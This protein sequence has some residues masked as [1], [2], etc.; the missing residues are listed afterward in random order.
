MPRARRVSGDID[1]N[2]VP[3]SVVA[4]MTRNLAMLL[5]AGVPIASALESLAIQS[6]NRGFRAVLVAIRNSLLEGLSLSQAIALYPSIFREPYAD[7]IRAGE[8]G[9]ALDSVLEK[10]AQHLEREQQIRRELLHAALYPCFIISVAAIVAVLLLTLVIP[11]FR[12][13]F[14]DFGVTLPWLTRCALLLSEFILSYWHFV[15]VCCI[16]AVAFV[17]QLRSTPSGKAIL[18][19]IVIKLPIFGTLALKGSLARVTSTLSTLLT[20]GVPLVTALELAGR[21]AGNPVIERELYKIASGMFQGISLTEQLSRSSTFPAT[22]STMVAV[23]EQ[24][25]A[26]DK[27]FTILSELYYREVADGVRLA[28]GMIEPIAIVLLG[29]VVGVLVLAVYLPIFEM[30]GIVQ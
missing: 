25:G 20:S 29:I 15:L 8:E 2:K 1:S 27:T 17:S 28:K 24:S 21:V 9:G 4:S 23:G 12:D 7:L 14:A 10:L 19:S 3:Y 16:C 5:N 26:L 18:Q 11:S 13:L 6:Q 22:V 30:G